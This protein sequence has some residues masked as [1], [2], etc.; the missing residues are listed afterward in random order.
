MTIIDKM[1]VKRREEKYF[2]LGVDKEGV[3]YWLEQASWNCDWYWGFGYVETFK[4]NRY[5]NTALD[6]DSHQHVNCMFWD[7]SYGEPHWFDA[8]K[9]I[10]VKTTLAYDEVW[11]FLDLMKSFYTLREAACLYLRGD[12]H[13]SVD[14]GIQEIL[15]NPKEYQRINKVLIPKIIAEVENLLTPVDNK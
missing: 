13:V 15:K 3:R 2:L 6:I 11:K 8:W 9:T 14:T 7:N 1:V 4:S 5:P 12:S 10:F